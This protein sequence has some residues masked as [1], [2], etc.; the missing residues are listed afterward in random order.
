MPYQSGVLQSFL[1]ELCL[2]EFP[3]VPTTVRWRFVSL[4]DE[5]G[6]A[7]IPRRTQRPLASR[8]NVRRGGRPFA[9]QIDH[10]C[11]RGVTPVRDPDPSPNLTEVSLAEL[12]QPLI[13]HSRPNHMSPLAV[14]WRQQLQTGCRALQRQCHGT[15]MDAATDRPMVCHI[16]LEGHRP[17]TQAIPTSLPAAGGE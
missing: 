16:V 17:Q 8:R 3:A 5:P 12:L 2:L 1:S 4:L 9:T 13:E 7:R 11:G 15:R 6:L 10:Q 14:C